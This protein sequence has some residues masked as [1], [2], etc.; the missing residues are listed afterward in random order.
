MRK[1]TKTRT[2]GKTT[3]GL[4]L[5]LGLGAGCGNGGEPPLFKES[6]K[7]SGAMVAKV[8][9]P[10]SVDAYIQT[11]LA[12]LA[13]LEIFRVDGLVLKLP[14]SAT[15]CYSLP[16]PGD[17]AAWAAYHAEQARQAP[18]LA[19]LAEVA[20][21]CSSNSGH[22]YTFVPSSGEE[23]VAALNALEIVHVGEL[24]QVEPKNNQACYNLPCP[25]DKA[26]ADAANRRRAV[27]AFTIAETVK[28]GGI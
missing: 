14:A 13:A 16:C 12:R 25:E 7:P 6:E 10:A 23:A 27:T 22:C 3:G 19:Q 20:E 24:I 18:R 17:D 4:A 28:A 8:D 9:D 2:M 11:S 5:A 26:A 15:A 1:R 21:A